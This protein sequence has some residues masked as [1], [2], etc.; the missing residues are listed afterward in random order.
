[1]TLFYYIVMFNSI[2]SSVQPC[3]TYFISYRAKT[4]SSIHIFCFNHIYNIPA[5]YFQ[6][7]ESR[8]SGWKYCYSVVNDCAYFFTCVIIWCLKFVLLFFLVLC[9]I[10]NNFSLAWFV[11]YNDVTQDDYISGCNNYHFGW[12][13]LYTLMFLCLLKTLYYKWYYH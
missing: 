1:M 2:F 5:S 4:T 3:I 13:L 8:I 12:N 11:P 6:V 10:E 9:D 7:I